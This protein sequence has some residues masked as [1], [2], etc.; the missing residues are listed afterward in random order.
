MKKKVLYKYIRDTTVILVANII[1]LAIVHIYIKH[2]ASNSMMH[3]IFR[4][5]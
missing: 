4:K 1:T 5:W 2:R 3:R